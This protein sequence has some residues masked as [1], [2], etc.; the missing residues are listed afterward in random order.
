MPEP[1][2]EFVRRQ[3]IKDFKKRLVKETDPATRDLLDKLL[4]EESETSALVR[5]IN[6]SLCRPA[7]PA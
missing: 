4:E 1:Y 3:N 7:A 6:C 2:D 5:V